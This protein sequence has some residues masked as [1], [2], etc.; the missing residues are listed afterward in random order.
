MNFLELERLMEKLRKYTD[1][2]IISEF[3]LSNYGASA[4]ILCKADDGSDHWYFYDLYADQLYTCSGPQKL[5][6]L[7]DE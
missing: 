6:K 4:Y 2:W 7:G 3:K 5:E 1:E